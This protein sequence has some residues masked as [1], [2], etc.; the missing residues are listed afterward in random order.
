MQ[1][2]VA[3]HASAS[4]NWLT[5]QNI[6]LLGYPVGFPDLNPIENLS[7]RRRFNLI[8][9]GKKIITFMSILLNARKIRS[10]ILE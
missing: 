10:H 1:N 3:I 6:N 8:H 9:A 2:N 7:A 4:T 5:T